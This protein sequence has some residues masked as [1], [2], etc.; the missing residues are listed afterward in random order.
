MSCHTLTKATEAI[1]DDSPKP[2]DMAADEVASNAASVKEGSTNGTSRRS[3][4]NGKRARTAR[5][6]A[7]NQDTASTTSGKNGKEKSASPKETIEGVDSGADNGRT[8]SRLA[9]ATEAGVAADAETGSNATVAP[10]TNGDGGR[11]FNGRR[12]R[13][14]TT[15]GVGSNHNHNGNGGSGGGGAAVGGRGPSWTELKKKA[16]LML[17]YISQAQ[18]D[19]AR[20][21][22]KGLAKTEDPPAR[23]VVSARRSRLGPYGATGA[24]SA[25]AAA[26]AAEVVAAGMANELSTRLVKWQRDF[27]VEQHPA[28]AMLVDAEGR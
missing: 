25:A 23:E 27:T 21:E 1:T 9:P 13:A 6:A 4:P 10:T 18:V 14:G 15:N 12:G 26:R 17:E 28:T 7:W 16:G 2:E 5:S 24:A 22:R 3:R 11:H 19:M 20:A 8:S